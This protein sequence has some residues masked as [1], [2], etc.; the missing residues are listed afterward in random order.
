M[1][2]HIISFS[3]AATPRR[4]GVGIAFLTLALSG[5]FVHAR[6]YPREWSPVRAVVTDSCVDVTGSFQNVGQPAEQQSGERRLTQ[7]LFPRNRAIDAALTVEI[8]SSGTALE[9]VATLPDGTTYRSVLQDSAKCSPRQRYIKDPNNPG[10]VNAEGIVGVMHTS[11]ELFR[12]ED[13]SLVVRTTERDLV[14][15]MLIPVGTDVRYWIR[16]PERKPPAP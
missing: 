14:I 9:A 11:L 1:S 16:F 7:T 6:R 3:R 2:R 5:C 4:A 12:C 15:A 13:G 8:E 10:T